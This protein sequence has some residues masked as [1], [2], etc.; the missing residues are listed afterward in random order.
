MVDFYQIWPGQIHESMSHR[1]IAE[2]IFENLLFG[3]IWPQK[4]QTDVLL[5]PGD[6]QS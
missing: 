3:V 2:T 4:S 6:T 5:I 1:N